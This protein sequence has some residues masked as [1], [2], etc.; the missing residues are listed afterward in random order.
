MPI[1]PAFAAHLHLLD[2]VPSFTE[3]GDDPAVFQRLNEFQRATTFGSWPW[4]QQ[5]VTAFARLTAL[6]QPVS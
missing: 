5:L 1:H 4:A 6:P 3:A 2:G